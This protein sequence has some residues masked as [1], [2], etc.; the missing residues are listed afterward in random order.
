MQR[1]K[2]F[3]RKQILREGRNQG[4]IGKKPTSCE[5]ALVGAFL[6]V[7]LL[8]GGHFVTHFAS[9]N[10]EQGPYK[11]KA[12][13]IFESQFKVV[14]ALVT[15]IIILQMAYEND[16]F[17]IFIKSGL[18]PIQDRLSSLR[19]Q[20]Q[21]YE[22]M[23]D[24]IPGGPENF[25]ATSFAQLDEV[26]EELEGL[27]SVLSGFIVAQRNQTDE[28]EEALY[29][30]VQILQNTEAIDSLRSEGID[31]T[32]WNSALYLIDHQYNHVSNPNENTDLLLRD[33]INLRDLLIFYTNGFK[34]RED[35]N[36][37]YLSE[38]NTVL[39]M[40][41]EQGG[42]EI[43]LVDESDID[44][45]VFLDNIKTQ[46]PTFYEALTA[47]E[48]GKRA[49]KPWD[50]FVKDRQ[51]L[52]DQDEIMKNSSSYVTEG[53]IKIWQYENMLTHTPRV[54]EFLDLKI[55]MENDID[56]LKARLGSLRYKFVKLKPEKNQFHGEI[57]GFCVL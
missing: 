12:S 41:Q 30:F 48:D 36:L 40:K 15:E 1:N 54:D 55:M 33:L 24:K 19:A 51:K 46:D 25:I 42:G 23:H 5:F 17:R 35:M 57:F 49:R 45:R 16:P 37:F 39:E 34:T 21:Q 32:T 7:I 53:F 9:T 28:L 56:D 6:I 14:D 38:Y 26:Q 31:V 4:K 3:K 8:L 20:L 10:E 52:N 13:H 29:D 50:D 47:S 44:D 11:I 2:N 43:L 27:E 22:K 18:T